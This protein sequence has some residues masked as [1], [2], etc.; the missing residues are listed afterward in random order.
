[1]EN[2]QPENIFEIIMDESVV[3]LR[4]RMPYQ[5]EQV[6]AFTLEES[7]TLR[8]DIDIVGDKE[9]SLILMGNKDLFLKIAKANH[10][11]LLEMDILPSFVG[12]FWNFVLGPV[13]K[14][15]KTYGHIVDI[16]P[17]KPMPSEGSGEKLSEIYRYFSVYE[18]ENV[19]GEI[20]I[21][22]LLK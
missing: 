13:I 7:D 4:N 16:T 5:V 15:I 2:S 1:M 11:I 3:S 19:I 20:A 21:Y 14:H 12:E 6:H 22:C 10:N 18:E 17:S 9:C 8:A